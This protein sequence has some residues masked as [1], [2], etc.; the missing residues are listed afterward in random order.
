M[1]QTKADISHSPNFESREIRTLIAV[2]G[3]ILTTLSPL[4]I[5]LVTSETATSWVGAVHL[6]AKKPLAPPDL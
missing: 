1:H 4:P 6:P 5:H 2:S 3:M